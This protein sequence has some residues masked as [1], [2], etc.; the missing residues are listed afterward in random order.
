MTKQEALSKIEGL[1]TYIEELDANTIT[2]KMIVEGAVF[3]C[4]LEVYI[5]V[6]GQCRNSWLFAGF[7]HNLYSLYNICSMTASQMVDWLQ[8]NGAKYSHQLETDYLKGM[9]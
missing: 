6:N 9:K 7:E 2:Q 8:K 4:A 3:K 1:K 5:V